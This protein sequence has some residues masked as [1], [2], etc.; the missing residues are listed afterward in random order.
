MSDQ[1]PGGSSRQHSGRQGPPP[2]YAQQLGR[3][4]PSAYGQQGQPGEPP[5]EELDHGDGP[6]SSDRPGGSGK[7]MLSLVGGA[8]VLAVIASVLLQRLVYGGAGPERVAEDWFEAVA[9]QDCRTLQQLSTVDLLEGLQPLCSA[10]DL[11]DDGVAIEIT[12]STMT[13]DGDDT[14]TVELTLRIR[15]A[16]EPEDSEQQ[17]STVEL[18]KQ[19]GDWKVLSAT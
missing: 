11:L 6:T 14:A 18:V 9:D 1:P 5:Y 2:G 19:N 16:G 12:D 8:L 3:H 15:V 7:R 4:G 10:D 17:E 13:A